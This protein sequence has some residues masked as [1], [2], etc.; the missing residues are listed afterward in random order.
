MTL[1]NHRFRLKDTRVGISGVLARKK[2]YSESVSKVMASTSSHDVR[3]MRQPET[4]L[5]V[6]RSHNIT[7]T[8]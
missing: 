2:P 3:R 4:R 1:Y 6:Y 5:T 7:A 8:L